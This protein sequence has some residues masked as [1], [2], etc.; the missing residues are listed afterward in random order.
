VKIIGAF[1]AHVTRDCSLSHK[2]ALKTM[3]QT[4]S[5]QEQERIDVLTKRWES[6]QNRLNKLSDNIY[7]FY[8]E[9]QQNRNRSSAYSS[10]VAIEFENKNL[11]PEPYDTENVLRV[12]KACKELK[13]VTARFHRV[14][15]DYYSKSLQQRAKLLGAPSVHMLCKS[16]ILENTHC[17]NTDNSDPKNARFYCVIMQY[18]TKLSSD[19]LMRFLRELNAKEKLG[20]RQFYFRLAHKED[21]L[22]LTGFKFNAV[23]PVGMTYYIPLILSKSIVDQVDFI[24]MGGGEVDIKLEVSV[25]EFIKQVKPFVADVTDPDPAR[26]LDANSNQLD[27]E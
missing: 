13:L 21:Q 24:Y 20:K 3:M 6:I 23:S 10:I 26:L 25:S 16:M 27:E 12:K 22:R 4:V 17:I 18:T 9:K 1:L 19:K 14:P 2:K 8:Q 5:E 7:H 11:E 15:S